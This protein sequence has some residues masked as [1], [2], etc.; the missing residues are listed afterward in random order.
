VNIQNASPCAGT[1]SE[2]WPASGISE[3]REVVKLQTP[4]LAA[5]GASSYQSRWRL[6]FKFTECQGTKQAACRGRRLKGRLCN[7][8]ERRQWMFLRS[9]P[10]GRPSSRTEDARRARR[11]QNWTSWAVPLPSEVLKGRALRLRSAGQAFSRTEGND[12]VMPA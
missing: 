1:S 6:G 2:K 11:R 10:Q 8:S 12:Q 4:D 9:S 5:S 3:D 7:G